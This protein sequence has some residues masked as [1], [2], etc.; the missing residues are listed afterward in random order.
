MKEIGIMMFLIGTVGVLSLFGVWI[1]K[2]ERSKSALL[3]YMF[4]L[5]VLFGGVMMGGH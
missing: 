3:F 1:Y 4:T 2:E 5:M